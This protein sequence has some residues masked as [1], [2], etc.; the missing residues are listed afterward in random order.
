MSDSEQERIKSKILAADPKKWWG[1]DFDVRFYLI[2][3]LK[4]CKNKK[5]LD[6]GGGIG[7]I[8]SELERENYVVN[9]DLSFND[10][11][12]SNTLVCHNSS[13]I[14][15]SITDI[16]LGDN[17]FDYV[18]SSSVLQYLRAQDMK[19]NESKT[20]EKTNFKTNSYPL[21]RLWILS[22]GL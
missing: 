21:Q 1:D 9:L 16:P 15:S 20:N 3:Q 13:I 11:K 19:N 10:L 5:I 22:N 17:S 7:I 14:C 8:S 18:I 4:K 2:S 6:L 12:F